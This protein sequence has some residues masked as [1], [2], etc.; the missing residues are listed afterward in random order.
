MKTLDYRNSIRSSEGTAVG[1]DKEGAFGRAT[2]F[3]DL[4]M[5]MRGT[6]GLVLGVTDREKTLF[7]CAKGFADVAARRPMETDALFQIGSVSKS[8]TCMALLQLAERGIIDLHAPVKKYLPWFSVKSKHSEITLHH[9]MTHTAG[10]VI[11]SDATLAA[12]TEVWDLR[13]TETTCEPGTFFHYSNSGYKTLGLILETVSGKSCGEIVRGG[14]LDA[15]GMRSTEPIITNGMRGRL[16]VAHLPTH[17]D[18]PSNG[19]S[20]LSPAPWFESDTADGSIC[21]PLE[22][23]LAYIRVILNR[24]QGPWGQVLS[25][26]SFRKMTTPYIT[27][28]DG[29]HGGGY[30]YGLNIDRSAGHTIIGHSGGMVG[31]YTSMIMDMDSG[32]GVM[33]MV[34]GPGFP[35]EVSKFALKAVNAASGTGEMP[36]VPAREHAFRAPDSSDYAG[37]YEGPWG[38]LEVVDRDGTLRLVHDGRESVLEP[39]EGDAF[40]SDSPGF[41]LFLVEFDREDGAIRRLHNGER[42]YY[43][44]GRTGPGERRADTGELRLDGHYRSHNP[45]LSNFRV[46]RRDAGLVF[47]L[48]AEHSHPLIHLGDNLFRIGAD[49]RSPERV[50]FDCVIDGVATSAATPGGGRFGRTFTP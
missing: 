11:G 29:L 36:E 14:I 20:G 16:A 50:G 17:D 7:T 45:W 25:S 2:E 21:A 22:D 37:T 35:D 18:R 6:P 27:P 48:P 31:H 1:T 46:V 3:A 33:A 24:G 40:Y 44:G 5:W 10:I 30:G 19:R 8:F 15:A 43:R 47:A 34:N 26:E 39:W 32:I 38:T 12:W 4:F 49:P 41:E 9:L 13:D 28:E 23:M 42:T